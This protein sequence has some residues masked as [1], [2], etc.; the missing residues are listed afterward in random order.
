MLTAGLS[1][2][3]PLPSLRHRVDCRHSTDRTNDVRVGSDSVHPGAPPRLRGLRFLPQRLSMELR[4]SCERQPLQEIMGMPEPSITVGGSCSVADASVPFR[5]DFRG[6]S[7]FAPY[8]TA[9]G[10]NPV[11]SGGAG[12]AANVD[13][14]PD[15]LEPGSSVSAELVRGDMGISANGTVTYIDGSKSLCLWP[16]L[17]VGRPVSVPCR[18]PL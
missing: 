12:T 7:G 14:V 10:F 3:W 15:R 4:K 6:G 2:L 9:A 5:C 16:S 18:K 17:Y 11:Q 8:F 1:V 13:S